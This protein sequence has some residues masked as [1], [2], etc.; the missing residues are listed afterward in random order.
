MQPIVGMDF[1]LRCS[2]TSSRRLRGRITDDAVP[3]ALQLLTGSGGDGGSEAELQSST[4]LGAHSF[5]LL[6]P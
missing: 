1:I 2:T 4:Q 6:D 5:F 3:Q